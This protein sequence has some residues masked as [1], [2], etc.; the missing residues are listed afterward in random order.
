LLATYESL[1]KKG[2][3]KA[4]GS[5]N[6]REERPWNKLAACNV[7][8][9]IHC[10][11]RCI[12]RHDSTKSNQTSWPRNERSDAQENFKGGRVSFVE[13]YAYRY[14]TLHVQQCRSETKMA[15]LSW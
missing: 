1:R 10:D 7:R 13:T 3:G 14:V 2:G 8:E 5:R 12:A 11:Q 9:A 15:L 4:C 6:K